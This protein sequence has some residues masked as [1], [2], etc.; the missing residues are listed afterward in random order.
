MV[1][2][3][4]VFLSPNLSIVKHFAG[5]HVL[6]VGLHLV[7]VA[8]GDIDGCA[9]ILLS[10]ELSGV[11]GDVESEIPFKAESCEYLFLFKGGDNA[12]LVAEMFEDSLDGLI[13][14]A[15]VAVLQL[16]DI[17]WVDDVLCQAVDGDSVNGLLFPVL[18]LISSLF[19]I[20]FC[21]V[22]EGGDVGE[23]VWGE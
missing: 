3:G 5:V 9:Y 17:G 21:L 13:G 12:P 20:E 14:V 15:D 11:G 6:D 18:L 23:F 10:I 22:D 7:L 19:H 4:F 1:G 8:G 2:R 16:P